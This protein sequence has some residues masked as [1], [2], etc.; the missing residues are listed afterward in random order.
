LGGLDVMIF[1][2]TYDQVTLRWMAIRRIMT[3]RLTEM[4]EAVSCLAAIIVF[5]V[6]MRLAGK[7][8]TF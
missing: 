4:Q 7:V 2:F 1:K 5:K 8:I 6:P 3:I